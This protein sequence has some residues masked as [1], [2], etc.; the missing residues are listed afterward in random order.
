VPTRGDQLSIT[1]VP[2]DTTAA[3]AADKAIASRQQTA[4]MLQ[5]A[6]WL[7]LIIV[8][9]VLLFL[10]RRILVPKGVRRL[11]AAQ[12][13][14]VQVVEEPTLALAGGANSGAL[15]AGPSSERRKALTDMA[16]NRPELVAG[17]IGRWIDEDRG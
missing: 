15:A 10:L 6:Q 1:T 4:L 13:S 17:V 11:Q 14:R 16:K 5:I 3:T 8:P 2:F 12:Y 7:G 9:L